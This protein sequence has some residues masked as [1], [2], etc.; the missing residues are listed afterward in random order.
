MGDDLVLGMTSHEWRSVVQEHDV[1]HLTTQVNNKTA[2]AARPAICLH[3]HPGRACDVSAEQGQAQFA[4][5]TS[6]SA[7]VAHDGSVT[8]GQTALH[9]VLPSTRGDRERPI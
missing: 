7:R 6:P 8:S 2:G 3:A 4:K 5:L 1:R 9:E